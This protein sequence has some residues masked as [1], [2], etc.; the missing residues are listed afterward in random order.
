MPCPSHPS[1]LD[2]SNDTWK[3]VEVMKLL[4]MQFSATRRELGEINHSEAGSHILVWS[5]SSPLIEEKW[6]AFSCKGIITLVIHSENP[7]K[8]SFKLTFRC[9][10]LV[11]TVCVNHTLIM[12]WSI[13]WS[14][15][16]C[17]GAIGNG[18]LCGQTCH[19]LLFS[20]S[21]RPAVGCRG[22]KLTTHLQ[23]VLRSRKCGF[24]NPLPRTPSW[25]SS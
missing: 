14:Q 18:P 15:Y 9:V 13:L 10:L 23:L 7:S 22:V 12:Q 1:W 20:T 24:I 5:A 25:R 8:R 3:S 6:E 17:D 21:S 16:M 11:W 19:L 2:H 4:I